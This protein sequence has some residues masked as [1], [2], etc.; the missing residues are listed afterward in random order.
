MIEWLRE[1]FR[2]FVEWVGKNAW[3]IF[4]ISI[5]MVIASLVLIRYLILWLPADYFL[6]DD[7]PSDANQ[8]PTLRVVMVVLRNILG[9]LF[10]LMGLIMVLPGIPGQ[11][12]L[13]LLIG[14]SLMDFPGK[15]R[16][17]LKIISQRVVLNA[18]NAIRMKSNK[19]PLQLPDDVHSN[20]VKNA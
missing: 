5:I 18:V 11:G 12:I 15:R 9:I 2:F 17:Q 1:L 10:V 16:L 19:P 14:L 7:Q 13:T 3:W 6:R 20:Q 4:G 8:H